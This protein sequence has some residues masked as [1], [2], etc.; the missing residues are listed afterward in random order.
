MK[1]KDALLLNYTKIGEKLCFKI[2]IDK[3]SGPSQ[4]SRTP[5]IIVELKVGA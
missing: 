1:I 4:R 2:L 3:F 5:R